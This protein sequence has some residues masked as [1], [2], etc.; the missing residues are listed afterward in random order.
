M[1]PVRA[2]GPPQN[3]ATPRALPGR[4]QDASQPPLGVMPKLTESRQQFSVATLG[5]VRQNRATM[6][7]SEEFFLTRVASSTSGRAR[8][9]IPASR[10]LERLRR[11]GENMTISLAVMKRL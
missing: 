1:T 9:Q 7:G 5:Q 6:N 8:N 2:R 10:E 3:R 4:S 11:L